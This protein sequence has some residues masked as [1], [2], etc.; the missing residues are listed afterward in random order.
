MIG[1]WGELEQAP[2]CHAVHCACMCACLPAC[3]REYLSVRPAWER[4]PA[5]DVAG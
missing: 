2:R 3:I 1:A 4:V 5:I